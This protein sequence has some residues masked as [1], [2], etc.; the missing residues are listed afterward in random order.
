MCCV[1]FI[2]VVALRSC[3]EA[4]LKRWEN[5]LVVTKCVAEPTPVGGGSS[6]CQ[7]LDV[8]FFWSVFP[9]KFKFYLWLTFFGGFG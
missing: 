1:E 2:A 5:V 9:S 8:S 6:F 3:I 4:A 7:G